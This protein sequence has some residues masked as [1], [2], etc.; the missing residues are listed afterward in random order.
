MPIGTTPM[1]E[2][3]LRLLKKIG[4]TDILLVTGGDHI[5]GFA[6]YLGDG[7][8]F[9][10][11]LTYRV[12]TQA[13]GI[14]GALA[15]AEGFA[16]GERVV[17]ILGDNIFD[18][19]DF[20]PKDFDVAAGQAQIFIKEVSDP[21]R[22]GVVE[23]DAQKKP[24]RIVEKPESPASKFAVTGLYAYPADI[25]DVIRT[26]KPSARGELEITDANSFY[27]ANERMSCHAVKGFW[28]DAGTPESLFGAHEW[29]RSESNQ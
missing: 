27:L 4:I 9:G 2:F 12:Q 19:R 29:V 5:G 18:E 3:P 13:N 28:S 15:L 8:A 16:A 11:S 7:S 26:L 23:F 24:I 6:E 1:I 17:V 20:S 22:F 10:V 25:F 14:A 21:K